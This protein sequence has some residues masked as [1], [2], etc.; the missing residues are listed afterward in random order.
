MDD[1]TSAALS[2]VSQVQGA[3]FLG[4]VGDR[5]RVLAAHYYH[6]RRREFKKLHYVAQEPPPPPDRK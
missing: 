4:H 6:P 2:T 1:E 5:V 3:N